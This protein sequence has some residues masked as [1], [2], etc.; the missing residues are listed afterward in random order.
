MPGFE[1]SRLSRA[2][3]LWPV[4]LVSI[5]EI[6]LVLFGVAP[7][8]GDD[9]DDDEDE[10]KTSIGLIVGVVCGVVVFM[11]IGCVIFYCKSKGSKLF[12]LLGRRY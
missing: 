3:R 5:S 2:H 8:N 12:H 6:L 1:Q 10:D 4:I 11:I 9:D 7:K